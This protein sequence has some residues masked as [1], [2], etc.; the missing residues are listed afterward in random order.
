MKKNSCIHEI[1]REA[2]SR[3]DFKISL[4][5]II[6]LALSTVYISTK[7]LVY[8]ESR[9]SAPLNDWVLSSFSPIDLNT[10]V[11]FI[12]QIALLIGLTTSAILP[13]HLIKTLLSIIL[14]AILRIIAMYLVPLEPPNDIIPLRDP[15]MEDIFYSGKVLM[16]DL[17][18]SGHTSSLL[19]LSL[20]TPLRKVRIYLLISA[21]VVASMLML[22]HVHYTIDIIAAPFF[23]L[24]A[25]T[26]ADTI[27]KYIFDTQIV[28]SRSESLRSLLQRQV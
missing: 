20:T 4:L 9:I 7:W 5:L 8:N 12:T 11:F 25:I 28:L 17:F 27:M 13:Y 24:L 10:P 16:K 2:F 21:G 26:I 3:V 19:L 6:S 1:W 14:I 23:T 15:F 22:Q 18:F